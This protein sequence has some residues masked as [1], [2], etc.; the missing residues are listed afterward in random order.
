MKTSRFC[1][2]LFI[3]LTWLTAL[4]FAQDD[5]IKAS[6]SYTTRKPDANWAD[7]KFNAENWQFGP[8]GFGTADTPNSRV[9]TKW[10]SEDIWLR[11]KI[12]LN[13]AMKKPSLLIHHDEDAQIYLDGQPIA[14]FSGYVTNYKVVP[15]ESAATKLLTSGD[16]LLAVHCHQTGGGQFIDVHLIEGDN[17][18]VLPEPPPATQPI[19]SDLITQWG[20]QVTPENAWTEYP[21][22][23]LERKQWIN[24]NGQWDYAISTS[25]ETKPTKWDGK[26]LVP[27][28]I[29][30]KLSGVQRLLQPAESLWYHRILKLDARPTG[31]V[32]LNF[33]AVDYQCTVWVNDQVVG[34]HTGA[35]DPFSFD[36]TQACQQGENSVVVAVRDA[37]G[38]TQLKGK[39]ILNPNGI[40][41]TRVSGIWQTVWVEQVPDR[42]I[43]QLQIQSDATAGTVTIGAKLRGASGS[44]EKITVEAIDGDKIVAR[45]EGDLKLTI[46]NAKLWSPSEPNLYKLRVAIHDASGKSIDEVESY[47]GI[48]SVGKVKDSNGHWRF[49]LNGKPIFHWGPLDQGWWPDGLLT[50]PSDDAMKFEIQYLKD[51]GFNMIRKHIK[52]EPRR[53]YYHCDRV[54]LMVWQD[55]VSGGMN[56]KWTRFQPNPEEANWSDEQ[57][58]QFMLE[59]ERMISTLDHFPSIVVWTPYNEAWGQHRTMD[60]GNWAVKR[61]P[62]RLIN[63]ASGGNFWPVG[64]VADWHEYPHPKFPFDEKRFK[65]FILVVGEFGGHGWPVE[66]HLWE[67]SRRNWG[68]GGLPKSI[69]EYRD[70]VRESIRLLIELKSKGIAAGVYTQTTDVEGEI[71]GLLTYDRKVKKIEEKELNKITAPLR[72]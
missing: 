42:S 5:N 35:N 9:F 20:S 41:Y 7:P 21:R 70:R 25:A 12:K 72:E 24:L 69:D 31:R 51:A 52:V 18:P 10:A 62:S 38:G 34:K 39:Q 54:G 55:Q 14:T 22:P 2:A 57:H 59:F 27:F 16:H 3:A 44:N 23:Q 15:L 36:I 60:V 45:A 43:E 8:G 48:R 1:T 30:S 19:L 53:Y 6:W 56:P 37:T 66:G 65:D 50:P 49:T 29:E 17:I 13:G 47:F 58:A 11:K 67:Q 64:D 32:L 68:Y 40:W 71:N 28:A 4:S 33:E 61:D 46:P 26:I 63:I